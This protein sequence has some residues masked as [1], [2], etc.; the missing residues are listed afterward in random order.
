MGEKIETTESLDTLPVE[1]YICNQ[2]LICWDQL[3]M[4]CFSC[5]TFL[6]CVLSSNASSNELFLLKAAL[7][8]G[9]DES[10][11]CLK[12]AKAY[13]PLLREHIFSQVSNKDQT[14]YF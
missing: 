13:I 3:E 10:C 6:Q 5:L 8:G 11:I 4:N 9:A 12:A 2:N 1:N 14:A 7:L